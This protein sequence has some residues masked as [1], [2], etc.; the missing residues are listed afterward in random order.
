[1]TEDIDQKLDELLRRE[2]PGAVSDDG[3]TL[4]VMRT[5]PIRPLPMRTRG[6][7]WMMPTACLS[8]GLLAWL[9]LLPAPLWQQIAREWPATG[10]GSSA[11]LLMMAVSLGTGLLG[12]AWALEEAT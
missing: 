11:A 6:Q 8:G 1:M 5:L 2:F 9:A 12:C 4:R 10:I 3:F 7:A